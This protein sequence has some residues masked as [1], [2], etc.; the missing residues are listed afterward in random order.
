MFSFDVSSTPLRTL[1]VAIVAAAC[2]PLISEWLQGRCFWKRLRRD[3]EL[4]EA[5]ERIARTRDDCAAVDDFRFSIFYR[6]DYRINERPEA[7]RAIVSST[8]GD[9][10]FV[11]ILACIAI[12]GHASVA[13]P[14]STVGHWVA[15]V[16]VVAAGT[17][18]RG[19]NPSA[20]KRPSVKAEQQVGRDGKDEVKAE[21][22]ERVPDDEGA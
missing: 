1:I 2:Y 12:W 4:C 7:W 22:S 3:A 20:G 5:L 21:K 9:P 17:V 11:S 19:L 10:L 8:L 18:S 14:G 6:L 16:T 13:E 15:T